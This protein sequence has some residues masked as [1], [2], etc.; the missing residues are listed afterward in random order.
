MSTVGNTFESNCGLKEEEMCGKVVVVRIKFRVAS[1]G[2][3]GLNLEL[4]DD[5]VREL[6]L[7][8]WW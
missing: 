1:E 2:M 3:A 8:G 7:C 5:V 6:V 4:E